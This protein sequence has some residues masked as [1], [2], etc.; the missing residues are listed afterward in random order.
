MKEV[1]DQFNNGNFTV[2]PKSE[3]PKGQTILPAVWQMRRK[4]DAKDGS[5]KKH[6]ARLNIDGSRMKRG[7]HY[8]ETNAPVAS[9]NSSKNAPDDD[10]GARVTHQANRLRSSVCAGTR[11]KDAVHEDPSREW[12]L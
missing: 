4:R 3:V 9:W 11:R 6:K 12:N 1:T 7:A 10:S 2:I 5:I 8:E